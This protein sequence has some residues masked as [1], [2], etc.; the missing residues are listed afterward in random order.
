MNRDKLKKLYEK[1]ELTTEDIFK[2]KHYVIITRSGIE[3]IAAIQDIT[4]EFE[5]VKCEPNFAAVSF[6]FFAIFI[7]YCKMFFYSKKK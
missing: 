5:V 4:I 3:K 2:H 1:Y 7:F 6:F